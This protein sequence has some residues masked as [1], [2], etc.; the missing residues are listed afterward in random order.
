MG[1]ASVVLPSDNLSLEEDVGK[2]LPDGW[3][4][5]RNDHPIEEVRLTV[6][7]SDN[8][9]LPVLTIR[10][11]LLGVTSCILLSFVNM[12]FAYRTNPLAIGSICAQ[13][14][15]LPIGR[16]LANTLPKKDI[17]VPF[18]N[19]SFSLNPGPFSMKEHCLITIFAGAGVGGIYAIHIVTIVKA[20]YHRDI[21]PM[22]CFLLAQTTQLL[23]YGWAGIYKKY[24]VESPYMWW[25]SNLVQV[26]LFKAIHQKEKRKKGGLTKFQF[27]LLVFISSFAYYAIPGFIFPTLSCISVL[28]LI[29][30][31]SVTVHQVGSGLKGLGVGSFGLDWSVVASFLGSP[32]ATPATAIFNI[33]ISFILAIY[34][35]LPIGYWTNT[36]NA[37]R[38]PI[39]SSHVFDYT[40]RSYNTSRIINERTFTL[41]V[42]EQDNYSKINLSIMFILTYGLGFASLTAS[43]MHVAL[44]HGKDIWT[45]WRNSKEYAKEKV[46]DVHTRLM[47][48][49]VSVPE[50]WFYLLLAIV[51]PLS[52]YTCIGFDKQ[53][54]LPWWGVLLAC[55]MALFFTLPIGVIVATTNQGPALNVITEY[56]I[57]LMLPGKP[58]A[59][60]TF[61]TYGTISMAQALSLLSDLNLGHYMKIPPKSMFITQLTGTIIA[62]TVYFA[63]AWMLLENVKNIC[64]PKNLPPD[65]P[66]TCPGDDV[67]Y[68]ASIIWGLVGPKRMFGKL[69]N[70]SALNLFFLIGFLLPIPF[71]FLSKAFPN[72][73]VLK[74]IHIPLIISGAGAI[75]PAHTV[76]YI[77]WGIVGIFFNHYIYKSYKK[78][79]AKHTYVMSAALD[80]GVAFMGVLLFVALQAHGIGGIEW[81][82]GVAGDYCELASCPTAPGVRAPGCPVHQ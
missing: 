79:W 17:K 20:F 36:Y 71:W 75:P 60:V 67:F 28:C 8:P 46:E 13:I 41:N 25:P 15:T 6:D 22:T 69:G 40:G 14:I 55:A 39:M 16:F 12:F 7:P 9:S 26:S 1:G 10:T 64:D 81:W 76:N 65:S 66:W 42:Q 38:F 82:G 24:L 31:K 37:K 56:I 57:G 3:L 51:I 47:R 5:E 78:W 29:F 27:F 4:L 43:I 63:T 62:S 11:W 19:W 35:I 49:Y 50:W 32:L 58:L 44:H 59:N 53:L 48:N 80:A 23:G 30:K 68:N 52:I 45:M 33:M 70:Y 34:V 2:H 21:H 77:M 54:Q 18:F 74:Y 61:K 72:N 73:K